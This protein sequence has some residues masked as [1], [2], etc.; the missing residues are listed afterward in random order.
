MVFVG[1][2]RRC[3]GVLRLECI[4]LLDRVGGHTDDRGAG[5]GEGRMQPGEVL[6]L[7]RASGRIG[8]GI[9]IENELLSFE[10]RERYGAAA[11]TGQAEIG[12][13]VARNE[14]CRHMPLPSFRR[15]PTV[16]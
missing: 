9:E 2:E 10:V 1:G 16:W 6:G 15:F 13:L 3:E 4:L 7:D 5:L 14:V 11:V 8:L 12:R